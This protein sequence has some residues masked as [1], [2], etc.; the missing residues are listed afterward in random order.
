GLALA[1]A[2]WYE[3]RPQRFVNGRPHVSEYRMDRQSWRFETD[4]E[5][6]RA[7]VQRLGFDPDTLPLDI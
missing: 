3:M 7:I 4:M 2:R 6:A 1:E 5:L